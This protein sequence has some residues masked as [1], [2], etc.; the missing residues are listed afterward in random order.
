MLEVYKFS[1]MVYLQLSMN[2][3][4]RRGW[5]VWSVS[6]HAPE[7]TSSSSVFAG[8]KGLGR[9]AAQLQSQARYVDGAD[10]NCTMQYTGDG[11]QRQELC[12]HDRYSWEGRNEIGVGRRESDWWQ[13]C[14]VDTC[15]TGQWRCGY[16]QGEPYFILKGDR[17]KAKYLT[18][19]RLR[20][21]CGFLVLHAA[22]TNVWRNK[23]LSGRF[24][25]KFLNLSEWRDFYPT[26]VVILIVLNT[27][28]NDDRRRCST[29]RL[30][31]V[32]RGMFSNVLQMQQVTT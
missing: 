18:I 23:E 16:L 19:T 27:I 20:Y 6:F 7:A 29:W 21:T 28:Q 9:G 12:S 10:A 26:T 25:L 11:R 24:S 4:R 31:Q 32:G 30:P 17:L 22:G 1:G 2:N 5:R 13:E 15:K 8:L 14:A 3:S